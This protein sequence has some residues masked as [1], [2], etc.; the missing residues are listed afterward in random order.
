MVVRNARQI[1]VGGL[2]VIGAGVLILTALTVAYISWWS[3]RPIAVARTCNQPDSIEYGPGETYHVFL[4]RTG[5]LL[6]GES[7]TAWV[8]RSPDYGVA[9]PLASAEPIDEVRCDWSLEGVTVTEVRGIAHTVPARVFVGGRGRAALATTASSEVVPRPVCWWPVGTAGE[10]LGLGHG[11]TG[12]C[13]T[14]WQALSDMGSS[15]RRRY[16]RDPRR[17]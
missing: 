16:R 5:S 6:G 12:L 17:R 14:V 4:K 13:P 10:A 3:T 8:G 1:V 2:A 7:V 15:A 9:V 11:A